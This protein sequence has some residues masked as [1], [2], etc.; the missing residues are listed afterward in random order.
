MQPLECHFCITACSN[1]CLI[2]PSEISSLVNAARNENKNINYVN[3]M[4]KSRK[5]EE[6][7]LIIILQ[8]GNR[9][10]C[11]SRTGSSEEIGGF[12][13]YLL[14]NFSFCCP[15]GCSN[16][17]TAIRS[18]WM[19][20]LSLKTIGLNYIPRGGI[21]NISHLRKLYVL[22]MSPG[23]ANVDSKVCGGGNIR[24]S[25]GIRVRRKSSNLR[26][27]SEVGGP[28]PQV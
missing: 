4:F 14:R 12:Q 27:G 15:L 11:A 24:S 3:H 23:Q 18:G 28:N 26:P 10:D 25:G 21:I 20:S 17:S 22:S 5:H 6:F 16:R 1:T 13:S 7:F 9:I 2:S 19:N 8:Y